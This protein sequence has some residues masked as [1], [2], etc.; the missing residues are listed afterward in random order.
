MKVKSLKVVAA[1]NCL[2][3]NDLGGRQGQ[4]PITTWLSA[5]Y[6]RQSQPH[7]SLIIS[8]LA[9]GQAKQER[10]T[11]KATTTYN[12]LIIK[13]LGETNKARQAERRQLAT[14]WLS[15]YYAAAPIICLIILFNWF[16]ATYK[17]YT[18]INAK[19][20]RML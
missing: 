7:N 4:Q 3:I 9:G 8:N 17:N 16:T 1:H 13:D 12:Y 18:C 11:G 5:T 6:E 15:A 14:I 20:I 2:I 19:N 10:K